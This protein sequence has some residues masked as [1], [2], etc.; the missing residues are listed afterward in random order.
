MGAD[1]LEDCSTDEICK[2]TQ[3]SKPSLQSYCK[4]KYIEQQRQNNQDKKGKD[5]FH[6]HK[7]Q[8]KDCQSELRDKH[9]P[10]SGKLQNRY[11]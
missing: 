5:K 9:K 7:E 11:E 6:L 3:N 4:V 8:E 1:K 10:D 2:E